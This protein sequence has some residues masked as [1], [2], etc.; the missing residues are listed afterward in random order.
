MDTEKL[1][2]GIYELLPFGWEAQAVALGAFT[3][4]REIES[5]K[6][7]LTMILLYLTS[8]DSLSNTAQMI[9]F[10]HGKSI[11]KAAVCR[12]LRKAWPWLKWMC[13]NVFSDRFD[14]LARPEWLTEK[15]VLVDGS[16]VSASGS[17]RADY[18]FHLLFNPFTF[19]FEQFEL[20]DSKI[21]ETLERFTFA[22][23]DLVV[24]DRQYGTLTGIEHVK[25]CGAKFLLR[26]RA[27]AF[28]LYDNEQKRVVLSQRLANLK[29]F[30]CASHDLFYK[31]GDEFKP[32]RICAM[33]K[34]E[35]AIA[36]CK[37]QMLRALHADER[38][39]RSD[40][41]KNMEQFVVVATDLTYE[42]GRILE[43]YRQRWQIEIVFK[44]LRQHRAIR[45]ADCRWI[46][47]S[48]QALYM[49]S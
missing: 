10:V 9:G 8:G 43:L 28:I 41:A 46:F 38:A 35:T 7:L 29:E 42:T 23:N 44:E 24:A 48:G 11:D 19:D 40:E 4:A 47:S 49:V 21:G 33:R 37:R 13:E 3:R 15:P 27:N 45:C 36:A 31:Q 6:E 18:N 20:T 26:M 25:K 5:P 12:R 17:R 30:E 34:D 14:V 39:S 2:E 22:E 16:G 1:L 32:I